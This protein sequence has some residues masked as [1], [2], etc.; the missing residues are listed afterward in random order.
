MGGSRKFSTV[1]HV[2]RQLDLFKD[3]P[4]PPRK[5][6]TSLS[7]GAPKPPKT[8]RDLIELQERLRHIESQLSDHKFVESDPRFARELELDAVPL[9][10]QVRVYSGLLH[11]A[12]EQFT[13]QFS[14]E[15]SVLQQAQKLDRLQ[16]VER[17]LKKLGNHYLPSTSDFHERSRLRLE[18]RSLHDDLAHHPARQRLS[19]VLKKADQEIRSFKQQNGFALQLV[20]R[21]E[22]Q[23]LKDHPQDTPEKDA[24]R[25]VR[26]LAY[27]RT[28]KKWF[29]QKISG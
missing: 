23:L 7:K 9:R 12:Q 24:V 28:L 5:K 13:H 27:V 3:R 22:R 25:T 18:S 19:T 21:Y 11:S 16:E 15:L 8:F 1:G 14:I 4:K 26:L 2:D 17:R 29:A 6:T 20:E 10:E